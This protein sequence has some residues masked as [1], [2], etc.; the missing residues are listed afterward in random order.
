MVPAL[1]TR[2][3][4]GRSNSSS[5]PRTLQTASRSPRSA[6]IG[7][8][9][10]PTAVT[11]SRASPPSG[12]SSLLTPTMSAPALARASAI[13]SPMPRLTP[14]T[15]ARRPVRS[16]GAALRG[17]TRF[18]SAPQIDQYFHD[19]GTGLQRIEGSLRFRDRFH[20]RDQIPGRKGPAREQAHG[21]FEVLTFVHARPDQLEFAPEQT[22]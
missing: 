5:R 8:N 12:S 15:R 18:I 17:G 20:Y 11:R 3:S 10:R 14:V 22:E 9:C 4:M 6:A 21:L 13:A 1:L 7:W 19:P 16:K 2:M